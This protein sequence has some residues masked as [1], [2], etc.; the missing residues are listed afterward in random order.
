MMITRKIEVFVFHGDPTQKKELRHTVYEWRDWV[1]KA[2]NVIVAHKFVQQNVADFTYF[3]DAVRDA[4]GIEDKDGKRQWWVKDV[5]KK[6]PGMSEQNTTYRIVAGM[7]KGKVPADIYSCLNQAVAK[8][9]KETLADYLKGKASI[10]SYKNNIPMPFSAKALQNIH[11]AVDGKFYFTLFG[12]P[13]ACRLGRDR[14]NNELMIDRCLEGEYKLCSSA[15]MIDDDKK[16]MFLLLCMDIPK[17]QVVVDEKKV[18][19]AYLDVDVPIRFS[20]GIKAKKDYDSG[21]KFFT[22]GSKEEYLYPRQ[23]IQ[24][25]VWRCQKANRYA[26]GGKGRVR[27]CQA[28]ERWHEKEKNYI[29]TKL[30]LYSKLLVDEAVKRKCGIILL[31]NQ[32]ERE[33]KAKEDNMKGD[34]FVLRNWSY[35]GLK[36]KIIYK[37]KRYGIVVKV[38]EKTKEYE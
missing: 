32:K 34:P 21:E 18:L 3:T 33:D 23:Q 26:K 11:K 35:Y 9:F 31:V 15:L 8:T 28:I 10:R 38:D 36:D 1:R 37:A 25:A 2:A 24:A 29:E 7:L 5:L 17:K 19:S 12:V 6:E 14:S 27:K 13:F 30:H 16:K 20:V 4:F 22:I